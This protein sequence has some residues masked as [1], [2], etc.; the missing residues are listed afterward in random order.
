MALKKTECAGKKPEGAVPSHFGLARTLKTAP[1][2]KVWLCQHE[3]Q[4]LEAFVVAS[5]LHAKFD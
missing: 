5:N 4:T 1:L 3:N 2:A